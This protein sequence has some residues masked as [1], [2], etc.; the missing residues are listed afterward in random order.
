MYVIHTFNDVHSSHI[1]SKTKLL[2]MKRDHILNP[3][4]SGQADLT[5][6]ETK[7]NQIGIFKFK[8]SE[9]KA[10]HGR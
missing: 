6:S 8:P 10:S 9:L 1:Q 5:N 4:S 2:W 7:I 3:T